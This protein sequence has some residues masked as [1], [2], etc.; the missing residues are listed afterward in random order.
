MVSTGGCIHC[1]PNKT[2]QKGVDN[3]LESQVV[4]GGECHIINVI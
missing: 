2:Q 1:G 3:K 4:S